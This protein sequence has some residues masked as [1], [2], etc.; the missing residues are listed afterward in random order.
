MS[1]KTRKNLL[2][3]QISKEIYLQQ[4]IQKS[5]KKAKQDLAKGNITTFKNVDNAIEWLKK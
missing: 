3:L 1:K 4:D 5:I 2:N